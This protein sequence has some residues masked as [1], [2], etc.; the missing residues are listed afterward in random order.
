MPPVQDLEA[1]VNITIAFGS[2]LIVIGSGIGVLIW[3]VSGGIKSRDLRLEAVEARL[4]A[5]ED[6]CVKFRESV[7]KRFDEGSE[8]FRQTERSLGR[9]EG[10]MGLKTAPATD[11][12]DQT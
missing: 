3:R 8:H 4:E 5:H 12:P 1:L 6:E 9:I 2:A 10:A 11:Q 7:V